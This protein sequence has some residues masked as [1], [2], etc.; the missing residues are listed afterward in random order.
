MAKVKG[1]ESAGEDIQKL[2]FEEALQKLEAIVEAMEAQD[3]PLESLLAR[4]QEGAALAQLC[5]AKLNEAELKI[6]Q[7]EKS[8]KGEMTL[9]AVPNPEEQ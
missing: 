8:G 4:Y 5:Q 1:A 2:P 6:Q 9:K 3:L 7:L